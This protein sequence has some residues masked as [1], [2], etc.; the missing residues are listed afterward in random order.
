MVCL[1]KYNCYVCRNLCES[2]RGHVCV[3]EDCFDGS[4]FDKDCGVCE[5]YGEIFG[6]VFREC[7]YDGSK[8]I[9]L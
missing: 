6:C 3:A 2:E 7:I 9:S 1:K 4:E 8:E 5:F